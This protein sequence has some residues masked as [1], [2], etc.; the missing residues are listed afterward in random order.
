LREEVFALTYCMEGMTYGDVER[1]MTVD[2]EWYLKRLHKQ[3]KKEADAMKRG[4]SIK[5]PRRR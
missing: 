3:L 1:M 4:G 5:K 2:R